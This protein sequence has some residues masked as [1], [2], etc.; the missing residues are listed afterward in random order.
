[1]KTIKEICKEAG[2][3]RKALQVYK[4]RGLA[5]TSNIGDDDKNEDSMYGYIWGK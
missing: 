2:V 3:T 1:M 5:K 4:D